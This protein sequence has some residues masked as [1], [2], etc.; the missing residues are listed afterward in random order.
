VEYIGAEDDLNCA[1][2]AQDVSEEKIFSM[3]PRDCPYYIVEKI[4]VAFCPWMKSLPEAK[5]K[6]FRLIA[7]TK[8]VSNQPSLDFI[9]WFTMRSILIKCSTPRK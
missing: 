1:D 8:E 4:V 9:L 7:L 6:R 5:M 2:L 3:L